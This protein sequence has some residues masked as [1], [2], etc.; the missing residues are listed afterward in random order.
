MDVTNCKS[1]GRLFNALGR[2]RL[3]PACQ[4]AL[5]EKFQKVKAY[6]EDH[7]DASVEKTATDND[8][9]IK[10]IRQWIK[11]ERLVLS[12]ATLAGI[13]CEKCG[14][15]IRTGRFCDKCKETMASQL[16]S[17]LDKPKPTFDNLSSE[18]DGNRMR[19]LKNQ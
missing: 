16:E 15:P 3:C 10:Q 1:C 13:V 9:T 12:S 6:L 19:Y 11:E 8:V 17:M 2:E 5:E 4:K 18:R 7:P 14:K